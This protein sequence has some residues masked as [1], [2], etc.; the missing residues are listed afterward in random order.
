MHKGRILVV[1]DLPDVRET[2]SG[3][4]LDEGY[5]VCSAATRAE[6][7]QKLNTK[8]FHVAVVDVRLDEAD[9]D[10][11]EGLLLMHEIKERYPSVAVII[12]TGYASVKMV[13]E[14]LEPDREGVSPAFGFLEKAEI[15]KLPEYVER[16]FERAVSGP[17][18]IADRLITEGENDRVEFKSSI[19][20]DFDNNSASKHLRESI[21]A[22]IAGMLN[23][24][25]GTLLI[26]VAD[27]GTVLGIEKDL[28]TLRKPDTDGFELAL[29]DIVKNYLGIEHMACVQTRFEQVD[30]KQICIV[31]VEKGSA[32]VFLAA[33]GTHKF[34]VRMGNSTCSLDVKATTSY[35][36]THWKDAR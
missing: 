25:G 27:D 35:I 19:R 12:L 24:E 36:Q 34:Y 7:L 16:V 14:T 20:W 13:R 29:T 8:Y 2:L 6:A 31:S 21:A 33:G 23:S 30:E 17:I 11:Q 28:Q 18:S 9:E 4:L 5:N 1:D 32:P 3:L 22:A 15:E 10:N 26:G